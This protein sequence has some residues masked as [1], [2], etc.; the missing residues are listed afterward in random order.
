MSRSAARDDEPTREIDPLSRTQETPTIESPMIDRV[1][2]DDAREGS[3]RRRSARRPSRP[4]SCRSTISASTSIRSKLPARSKTRL[5]S[6]KDA[7]REGAAPL[8]DDEMTQLA[9]SLGSFDRTMEAPRVEKF[10]IESTGT[11]YIDQVDLA[12]GDTVEQPRP[13]IDSTASMKRPLDADGTWTSIWIICPARAAD[14]RPCASRAPAIATSTRFSSDVFADRTCRS[15]A[16]RSG[17][18]RAAVGR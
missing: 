8:R 5:R 11:I 9:P 15:A 10:D 18:R 7:T 6:E 1:V 14:R 12:G 4:P 17:R 3:T 13:E 2:A 16:R